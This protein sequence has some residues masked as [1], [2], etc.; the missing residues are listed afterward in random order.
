MSAGFLKL[1]PG[2]LTHVFTAPDTGDF[3]DHPWGF[4]THV[5][6]G[7]YVEEVV[8]P[9]PDG[10]YRIKVFHRE[11][12][13]SHRVEA[14]TVHRVVALPRGFCVTRV[15]PGRPERTSGFNRLAGTHVWHRYWH[16]A[17]FT[18]LATLV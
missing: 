18:R 1:H 3:H 7:G 6:A 4:V 8:V 15:E 9:Q 12:G 14:G 2:L 11:P 5:V 17:D 13:T 10:S 16:E